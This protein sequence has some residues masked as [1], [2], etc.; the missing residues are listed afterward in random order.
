[1]TGHGSCDGASDAC[2]WRIRAR[3]FERCPFGQES[4]L[5]NAY[6]AVWENMLHVAPQELRCRECN[7]SLLVSVCIV[8][9]AES[10]LLPIERNQPVIADGNAMRIAAQIA[11]HRFWACHRRFNIDDPVF[12]MQRLKKRPERLG[13]FQRAG[14]AAEAELVSTIGAL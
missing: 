11:E 2:N 8:L 5:A 1:M 4:K 3:L 12:P 13:I 10:D 6:E 14:G 9:P 7:E